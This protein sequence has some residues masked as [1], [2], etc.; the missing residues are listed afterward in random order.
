MN[1]SREKQMI[2]TKNILNKIKRQAQTRLIMNKNQIFV[3]R[4][5]LIKLR[6]T[7]K[8]FLSYYI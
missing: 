5:N 7:S 8:N 1:L 2:N 4:K 6:M 3:G